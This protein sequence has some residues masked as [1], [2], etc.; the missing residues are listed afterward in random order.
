M[1]PKG[2]LRSVE[3][4][5]GGRMDCLACGEVEGGDLGKKTTMEQ[6]ESGEVDYE[7]LCGRV[8]DLRL[9]DRK[10]RVSAREFAE[11]MIAGDE[12]RG[13]RR[14]RWPRWWLMW[15]RRWSMSLEPKSRVGSTFRSRQSRGTSR[16]A[17]ADAYG[18][19]AW[20]CARNAPARMAARFISFVN[21]GMIRR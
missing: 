19:C 3:P 12:G 15:G 20:I 5:Q 16:W 4:R 7:M 18:I 8:E 6:I 2:V 21:E 10:R 13:S 11:R 14:R 17:G 9:L 1:D